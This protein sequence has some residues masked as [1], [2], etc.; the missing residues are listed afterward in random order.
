MFK[1]DHGGIIEID[2]E[3]FEWRVHREPQWCSAGGWKG[4]ALAVR[5]IGGQREAIVEWPMQWSRSRS[6]PQRQRPQISSAL[7]KKG[8]EAAM[9]AGWSPMSR[10][11]P[12]N[13]IVEV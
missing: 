11:H 6:V 10:G 8:V 7:V 3:K 1:R 2:G 12:I 5:H 4:F 9:N 13:V